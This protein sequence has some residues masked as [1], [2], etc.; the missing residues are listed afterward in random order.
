MPWGVGVGFAAPSLLP[1]SK[2]RRF[3]SWDSQ[4]VSARPHGTA[5]GQYRH[6]TALIWN[7]FPSQKYQGSC[8]NMCALLNRPIQLKK[9]QAGPGADLCRL[10]VHL[11]TPPLVMRTPRDCASLKSFTALWQVMRYLV[12]SFKQTKADD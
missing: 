12:F 8:K 7:H 10:R 3:P 2:H 5:V 6:R 9:P 1:P 4:T 11:K